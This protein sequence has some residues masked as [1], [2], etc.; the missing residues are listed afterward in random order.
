MEI[1]IAADEDDDAL[2]D[3][4]L[5]AFK[6]IE[7]I[8]KLMSFHDP[9]SEL[10]RMNRTAHLGEVAISNDLWHVLDF[11]GELHQASGGFFD[12]SIA[13]EL[14]RRGLLPDHGSA[15]EWPSCWDSVVL[16]HQ[17]VRFSAP[18]RIDLGG[19]AKGYAVD[20]ALHVIGSEVD[21]TVNAGGDLAMTRWQDRDVE[22]RTPGSGGRKT[23]KMPM[24]NRSLA[25][26]AAYFLDSEPVIVNPHDR[27]SVVGKESVSVFADSCMLADALTKVSLLIPDPAVVLRKYDATGC[28]ITLEGGMKWL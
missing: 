7:R 11:T 24:K 3:R 17:S 19:I 26:S 18:L 14:V 8:Q 22:I 1:H 6:E 2:L 4:S 10:S 25:T 16:T 20:R 5:A 23:V 15:V 21:A 9:E 28:I 27:R 12:P 13:P